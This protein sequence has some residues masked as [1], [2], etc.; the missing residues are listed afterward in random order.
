MEIENLTSSMKKVVE[1]FEEYL[2]ALSWST[3][4]RMAALVVKKPFLGEDFIIKYLIEKPLEEFRIIGISSK[5]LIDHDSNEFSHEFLDAVSDVFTDKTLKELE[6]FKSNVKRNEAIAGEFKKI[7]GKKIIFILDFRNV[8]IEYWSTYRI[9]LEREIGNIFVVA[10]QEQWDLAQ[11]KYPEFTDSV[12][13]RFFIEKLFNNKDLKNFTKIVELFSSKK[14][15]QAQESKLKEFI[16]NKEDT[17]DTN[18]VNEKI[19][20]LL[21]EGE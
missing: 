3:S 6:K 17:I 1:D 21:C 5:T 10:I 8:K 15:S 12:S 13:K 9:L 7:T 2:T 18:K 4:P 14:L 19:F 20:T 16:I 11:K